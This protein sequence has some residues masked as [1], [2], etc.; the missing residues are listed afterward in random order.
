MMKKD[1]SCSDVTLNNDKQKIK[2]NK[3]NGV[4]NGH[5]ED[6][7]RGCVKCKINQENS[8]LIEVMHEKLFSEL[9]NDL[10]NLIVKSDEEKY[11]SDEKACL[12]IDNM[13]KIVHERHNI[14]TMK[15]GNVG[16]YI[17]GKDIAE[18]MK[19]K[20]KNKK[21]EVEQ[22][23]KEKEKKKVKLTIF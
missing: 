11:E 5:K 6:F 14:E 19:K 9:K 16:G 21:E 8:T 18:R 20:I 7:E 13:D 10:F 1:V 2:E 12:A 3:S 22:I 4:D 23:L 17:K 15:C